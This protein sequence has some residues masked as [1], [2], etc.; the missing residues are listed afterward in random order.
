MSI[1]A[2]PDLSGLTRVTD[3]V[4]MELQRDVAAIRRQVDSAT[5]SIAGE[6]A[7]RSA[8][9]LGKDGLARRQG[10]RTPEKLISFLTGTSGAEARD[11]VRVGEVLGGE[12]AWLAPVAE[13]V[14]SGV[15]SVGA[16]A[17]I[18]A[19][20]GEPTADVAVDDLAHAAERLAREVVGLPPERA[21][22][23]ARFARDVL[24]VEHV[25]ERE[26]LLRSKRGWWV[27]RQQDGNTRMVIVSDPLNAAL[28]LDARDLLV[29]PKTRGVRFVDPADQARAEEIMADE[30]SVEQL[31]FDGLVQIFHA[32]AQVDDGTIF[33]SRAPSVR[34][35]TTYAELKR[36]AGFAEIDGQTAVV[37]IA[38]AKRIVCTTGIIPVVFDPSGRLIDVAQDQRTHSTRQRSGFSIRDGGCLIPWCGRP[39]SWCEIHHPHLW[40]EG[41]KSTMANGVT[42]CRAHHGW[43]HDSGREIVLGN[44]RT[45]MLV[46]PDGIKRT[47]LPSKSGGLGV[48]WLAPRGSGCRHLPT[49]QS[50]R[51]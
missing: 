51:G 43:V 41:G 8:P 39:P 29:G 47:A 12:A 50:S 22:E 3:D 24:D 27:T 44:D 13:A 38:T 25:A 42:L 15:L 17:A 6:I 40:S 46:E 21:A 35:K 16:A 33:G 1:L 2:L 37:S 4:L 18:R 48:T 30:R 36:D 32:A 19:G 34:V 11:L 23:E 5:A 9:Q 14:N 31:A 7:R 28:L 49:P 10:Q 20:L 26:A 45:Y